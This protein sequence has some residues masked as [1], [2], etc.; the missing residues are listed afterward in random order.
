MIKSI[1]MI[2]GD[3]N[4]MK[5]KAKMALGVIFGLAA[6]AAVTAALGTLMPSATG[7]KK[8]LRMGGTFILGMMVGEHA[9]EYV[10]KVFDETAEA[11]KDAKKELETAE[12]DV[13]AEGSV[14]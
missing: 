8:L 5:D 6:D 4:S 10:Y 7:W 14:K 2:K 9:E 12:A 1:K 11:L 13:A 3:E